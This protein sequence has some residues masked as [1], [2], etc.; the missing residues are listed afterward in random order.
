MKTKHYKFKVLPLFTVSVVAM[1]FSS[2][3]SNSAVV[4][5]ASISELTIEERLVRVRKHIQQ[6]G[7]E[8]IDSYCPVSSQQDDL[9]AK[10]ILLVKWPKI[11]F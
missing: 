9:D 4:E 1:I 11:F 5:A 3:L 8:L 10:N 6:G 7:E 2:V